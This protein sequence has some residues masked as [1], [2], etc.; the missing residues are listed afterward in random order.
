MMQRL[1]LIVHR[2]AQILVGANEFQ[3]TVS[4]IT[5][6]VWQIVNSTAETATFGKIRLQ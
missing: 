2:H 3:A 6:A 5:R 4:V 1:S